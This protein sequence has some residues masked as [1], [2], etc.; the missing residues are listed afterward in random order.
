M[1]SSEAKDKAIIK[2]ADTINY[3]EG[4]L[5]LWKIQLMKIC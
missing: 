1:L 4:Y 2:T 5:L 3:C